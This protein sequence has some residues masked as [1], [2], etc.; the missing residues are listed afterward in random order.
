MVLLF[1]LGWVFVAW[2]DFLL[3]CL[4]GFACDCAFG[5]V[6]VVL[7]FDVGFRFGCLR[8]YFCVLLFVLF[9]RFWQAYLEFGLSLDF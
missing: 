6:Q 7:D 4:V 5:V 3:A 2:V 9:D 8:D 1:S